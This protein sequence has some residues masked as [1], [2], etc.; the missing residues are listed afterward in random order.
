MLKT[1][2]CYFLYSVVNRQKAYEALVTFPAL[3]QLVQTSI[4]L[5]QPSLMTARTR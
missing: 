1:R 4:F 3:M 2:T 5:T